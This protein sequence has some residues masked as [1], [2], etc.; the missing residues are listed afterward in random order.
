MEGE[1]E[2]DQHQQWGLFILYTSCD[3]CR[4]PP[5]R[6]VYKS[7]ASILSGEHR[8]NILYT[9]LR[10]RLRKSKTREHL[11]IFA[12]PFPS[13]SFF[14]LPFLGFCFF[15]N[16]IIKKRKCSSTALRSN[17]PMLLTPIMRFIPSTI[18]TLQSSFMRIETEPINGLSS[19]NPSNINSRL[20][21]VSPN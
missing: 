6:F 21:F 19:P 5:S 2:D 17:P 15:P 12:L 1:E 7:G 10:E 9:H 14:F 16:Q 3:A 8:T 20:I 11:S 4:F 18:T 13:S